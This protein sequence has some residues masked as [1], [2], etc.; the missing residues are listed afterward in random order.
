[1]SSLQPTCLAAISQAHCLSVR[2]SPRRCH[3]NCVH[4]REVEQKRKDTERSPALLTAPVTSVPN[5]QANQHYSLRKLSRAALSIGALAWLTVRRSADGSWLVN[6]YIH[7]GLLSGE[8]AHQAHSEHRRH[9][10]R[11]SCANIFDDLRFTERYIERRR[12][13]MPYVAASR[14]R[15]R[16]TPSPTPSSVRQSMTRDSRESVLVR[17]RY[18]CV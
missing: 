9:T 10:H 14:V 11:T 13:V 16:R 4:R 2:T 1:M 6:V 18:I 15:T 3:G 17:C 8:K 5:M 7:L 12:E